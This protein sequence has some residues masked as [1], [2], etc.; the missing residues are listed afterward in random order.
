[1]SLYFL[2]I[3]NLKFYVKLIVLENKGCPKQFYIASLMLISNNCQL[4][5]VNV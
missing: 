2:L 3:K 4:W 1:M 5:I